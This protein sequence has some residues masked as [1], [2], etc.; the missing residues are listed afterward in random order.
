M[1]DYLMHGEERKNA[2]PLYNISVSEDEKV[3]RVEVIMNMG[4]YVVYEQGLSGM[5]NFFKR[6]RTQCD[7]DLTIRDE[8]NYTPSVITESAK[9]LPVEIR[10]LAKSDDNIWYNS[11]VFSLNRRKVTD[12]VVKDLFR[13]DICLDEVISRH[14]LIQTEGFRHQKSESYRLI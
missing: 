3:T 4:P 6:A 12:P 1:P 5:L 2:G 11:Q 7:P 13:T 14:N 8:S 9:D 10:H